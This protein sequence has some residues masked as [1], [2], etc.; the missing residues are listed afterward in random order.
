[1]HLAR[2]TLIIAMRIMF[3]A[4]VVKI[5]KFLASRRNP[6]NQAKVRSTIQRLGKTSNPFRCVGAIRGMDD[7][8]QQITEDI[9][10]NMPFTAVDFF[11][12]IDAAFLA[13]IWGFDRL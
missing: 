12:P 7:H 6:P 11:S 4:T 9:R 1:M 8:R 3:S 5:S 10:D 2:E 13:G